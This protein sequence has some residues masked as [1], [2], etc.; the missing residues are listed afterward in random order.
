M[1]NKKYGKKIFLPSDLIET[2][3]IISIVR[4]GSH[5]ITNLQLLH[6]V[7]HDRKKKKII[8]HNSAKRNSFPSIVCLRSRVQ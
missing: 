8:L 5:K 1:K 2:D 7:C 3:Y 4:G 6:A